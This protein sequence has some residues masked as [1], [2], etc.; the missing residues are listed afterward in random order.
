MML[1]E[2]IIRVRLVRDEGEFR[3][4]EHIVANNS[5]GEEDGE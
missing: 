5:N 1:M 2:E 3:Q 4:Y